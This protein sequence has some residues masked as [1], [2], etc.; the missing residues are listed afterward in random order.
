M[1]ATNARGFINGDTAV[2]GGTGVYRELGTFANLWTIRF[3]DD[4]ARE[5]RMVNNAV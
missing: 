1:S 5:F 2:V 3:E 4:R